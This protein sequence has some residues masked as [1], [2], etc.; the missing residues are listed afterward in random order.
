MTTAFFPP[1][2]HQMGELSGIKFWPSVCS[3][4]GECNQTKIQMYNQAAA[5]EAGAEF[6]FAT[7]R[8][9]HHHAGRCRG[10]SCGL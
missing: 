5:E 9:V 3:F 8:R 6:H 1:T 2:E 7:D 10:G 4:Y